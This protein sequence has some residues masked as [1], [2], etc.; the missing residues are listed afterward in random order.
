MNK[1]NATYMKVNY[2]ENTPYSVEVADSGLPLVFEK[3]TLEGSINDHLHY[4]PL[5]SEGDKPIAVCY[6]IH[7]AMELS[8]YLE[9]TYGKEYIIEDLPYENPTLFGEDAYSRDLRIYGYIDDFNDEFNLPYGQVPSGKYE[10]AF[11]N[12]MSKREEE[13][14]NKYSPY[15]AKPAE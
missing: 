7:A 2:R 4:F 12:Y 9:K 1:E 6:S 11:M 15:Y 8:E 10:T 13:A 3:L 14:R 5:I